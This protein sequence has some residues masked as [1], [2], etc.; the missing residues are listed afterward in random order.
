MVPSNIFDSI[1]T[2]VL[3][4]CCTSYEY[5]IGRYDTISRYLHIIILKCLPLSNIFW[6]TGIPLF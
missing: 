2:A 3:L 5:R 6:Y 1:T 4:Y